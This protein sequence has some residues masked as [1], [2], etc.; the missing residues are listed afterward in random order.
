[1]IDRVFFEA[2]NQFLFFKKEELSI[3]FTIPNQLISNQLIKL[4]IFA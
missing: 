4:I 3:L 2:Y 1:M